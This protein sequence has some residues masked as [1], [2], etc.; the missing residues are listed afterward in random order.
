MPKCLHSKA[1]SVCWRS[2]PSLSRT[3]V[4]SPVR[5]SEIACKT[6]R[7]RHCI[8]HSKM[9]WPPLG[10]PIVFRALAHYSRSSPK[11]LSF[12]HT[13]SRFACLACEGAWDAMTLVND[14]RLHLRSDLHPT[15]QGI[16]QQDMRSAIDD[17][18]TEGCTGE[19]GCM[20]NQFSNF[21]KEQRLVPL[22]KVS[23]RQPLPTKRQRQ[24]QKKQ[25]WQLQKSSKW[26]KNISARSSSTT[27]STPTAET[28]TTTTTSKKSERINE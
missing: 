26:E 8:H 28:T 18:K 23:S 21:K 17:I 19:I 27:T 5:H 20:A 10:N 12:R 24:L 11:M 14:S 15:R 6:E 3:K 7:P 1:S 2:S 9:A 25:V 13:L 22:P 4:L 16:G